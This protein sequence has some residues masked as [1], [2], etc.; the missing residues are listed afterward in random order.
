MLS[1]V[2]FVVPATFGFFLWHSY[3]RDRER[4][5]EGRAFSGHAGALRWG[6]SDEANG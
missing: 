3:R 4:A 1:V 6:A 2:F 5:A